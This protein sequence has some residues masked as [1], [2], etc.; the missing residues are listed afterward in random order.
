MGDYLSVGE[1][2]SQGIL[3]KNAAGIGGSEVVA[4]SARA[5]LLVSKLGRSSKP[6]PRY[7]ILVSRF[8]LVSPNH[9]SN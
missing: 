3:L 9:S 8:P 5:H 1:D 2:N 4:F 6:S 7:V